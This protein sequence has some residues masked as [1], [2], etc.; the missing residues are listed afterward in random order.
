MPVTVRLVKKLGHL[1]SSR[2]NVTPD[3]KG[4]SLSYIK[5]R[6]PNAERS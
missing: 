2:R 4:N 6:L 5:G 1:F 3:R